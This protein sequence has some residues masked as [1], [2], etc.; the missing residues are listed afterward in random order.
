MML[1]PPR[2][3]GRLDGSPQITVP[4]GMFVISKPPHC[5]AL[6]IDSG[7]AGP[8]ANDGD[9]TLNSARNPTGS[10][11][12]LLVWSATLTDTRRMPSA[13]GTLNA[14]RKNAVVN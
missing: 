6:S 1:V 12:M 9:A 7:A 11:T 3:V 14:M 5:H 2:L 4:R 13:G 8:A 10:W